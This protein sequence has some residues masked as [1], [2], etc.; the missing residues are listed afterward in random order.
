MARVILLADDSPVARFEVARQL[1]ARGLEV[2]EREDAVAPPADVVARVAC[3]LLDLD[4]GCAGDGCD[5]AQA[6][7]AARADLPVAFFSASDSS[8]VLARAAALGPVFTKPN[9]LG[10]A[11]AWVVA[12]VT[13]EAP[14]MNG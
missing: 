3:A 12:H 4:M 6:L 11:I 1:R 7:R 9:Q 5:L 2:I 13:G 8:P 10:T 14:R